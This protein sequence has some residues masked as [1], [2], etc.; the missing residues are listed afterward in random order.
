MK[1]RPKGMDYGTYKAMCA[2]KK[3]QPMAEDAF[4]AL[5]VDESNDEPAAPPAGAGFRGLFSVGCEPRV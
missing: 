3:E 4:K 5:P 1:T 2:A